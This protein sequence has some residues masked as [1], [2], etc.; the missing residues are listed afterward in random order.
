MPTTHVLLGAALLALLLLIA[1]L[2]RRYHLLQYLFF[3]RFPILLALAFFAFPL[4]A[5][6]TPAETLLA[7]LF[8]L[9][10][11]Q[12]FVVTWLAIVAAWV[13]TSAAELVV[14]GI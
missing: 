13:V 7:N 10:P 4:V 3:C 8:V 6:W 14:S 5:I 1:L 2:H 9:T 11:P 12:L